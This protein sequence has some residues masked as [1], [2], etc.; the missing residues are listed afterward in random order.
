MVVSDRYCTDADGVVNEVIDVGSS[1][2]FLLKFDPQTGSAALWKNDR[3]YHEVRTVRDAVIRYAIDS[4]QAQQATSPKKGQMTPMAGNA[5][6]AIF[7]GTGI[8]FTS[9]CLSDN[10]HPVRRDPGGHRF[11]RLERHRRVPGLRSLLV[12]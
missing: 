9:R 10:L 8:Y 11:R 5:C 6:S 4:G 2:V 3:R 7:T 12:G 1:G